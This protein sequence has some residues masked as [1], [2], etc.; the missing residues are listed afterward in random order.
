MWSLARTRLPHVLRALVLALQGLL[1]E[2]ADLFVKAL[3]CGVQR[4]RG[5]SVFDVPLWGHAPWDRHP[6]AAAD[7]ARTNKKGA[8]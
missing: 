7:K 4:H 2:R 8:P 1:C 3:E 5:R 6:S